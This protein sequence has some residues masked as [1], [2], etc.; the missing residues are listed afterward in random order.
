MTAKASG[1]TVRRVLMSIAVLMM[2]VGGFLSLIQ[3]GLTATSLMAV[4]LASSLIL[5]D[6]AGRPEPRSFRAYVGFAM[7]AV[8]VG[9]AVIMLYQRAAS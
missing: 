5:L 2:L 9:A 8:A 1:S 6:L 7:M 3:Q 4:S